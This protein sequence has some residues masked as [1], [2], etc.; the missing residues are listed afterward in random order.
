VTSSS[1]ISAHEWSATH[2]HHRTKS[3][4]SWVHE[5]FALNAEGPLFECQDGKSRGAEIL[6]RQPPP[7]IAN[8][9]RSS[10]HTVSSGGSGDMYYKAAH[11]ATM[12]QIPSQNESGAACL[13]VLN[14][15]SGTRNGLQVPES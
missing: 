2:P 6:N 4:D 9:A 15:R 14:R 7:H 8:Y 13:R 3:S 10:G 12:R 11:A 1:S 5:S